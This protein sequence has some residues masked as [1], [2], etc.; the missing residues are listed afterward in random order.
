MLTLLTLL[1]FEWKIKD[2]KN[3][4]LKKRVDRG[5]TYTLGPPA[6]ARPLTLDQSLQLQPQGDHE[7]E[8]T[9][10]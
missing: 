5:S 6:I 7:G 10:C 9:R 8:Q 4:R 2:Y 1:N 3:Y